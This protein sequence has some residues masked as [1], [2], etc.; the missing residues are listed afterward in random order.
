MER[1]PACRYST[2]FN[3]DLTSTVFMGRAESHTWLARVNSRLCIQE[4]NVHHA[5]RN[6]EM[7]VR[8]SGETQCVNVG[9]LTD[10]V[11]THTVFV[12]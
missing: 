1:V 3:C 4:I 5:V 10:P 7:K 2:A 6:L 12:Y 9:T 11:T 8:E